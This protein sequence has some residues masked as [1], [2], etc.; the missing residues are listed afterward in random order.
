MVDIYYDPVAGA[1]P[2]GTDPVYIHIGHSNWNEVVTPDPQM[3]YDAPSGYWK[4]SYSIPVYASSVEFVTNDGA[5]TWDNNYG[6]DW[7]ISISSQGGFDM[8]GQLDDGAQLLAENGRLSLWAK[9]IGDVLYVATNA[10]GNGSDSHMGDHFIYVTDAWECFLADEQDNDYEGWFD[11]TGGA[12]AASGA[13]ESEVLEGILNMAAEFS[14]VPSVVYLAAAEYENPDAGALVLQVP[15]LVPPS[16]DHMDFAEFYPYPVSTTAVA[17]LAT[18]RVEQISFAISPSPFTESVS[19]DV[20]LA[21]GINGDTRIPVTIDVINIRGQKVA[22]VFDGSLEPGRH[23]FT[24]DGRN[25]AGIGC[26]SGVYLLALRSSQT[27][28]TRKAL[29]VR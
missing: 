28:L 8:D 16:N 26:A 7:H 21:P 22:T 9:V 5:G 27:F 29:L 1:L 6:A 13:T 18:T 19:I 11:A 10:A 25:G 20:L 12:G 24:W 15:E 3:T 14:E 23:G 17:S 2:D 4:Y